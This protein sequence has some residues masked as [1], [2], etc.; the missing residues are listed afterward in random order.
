MVVVPLKALETRA[1]KTPFHFH[2]GNV[3]APN[4]RPGGSAFDDIVV[5]DDVVESIV[6]HEVPEVGHDNS[7][8]LACDIYLGGAIGHVRGTV[9][10]PGSI[11]TDDSTS[12][13]PD[14]ALSARCTML[15]LMLFGRF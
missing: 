2:A 9:G 5:R 14:K 8:F 10:K 4:A 15:D 13:E 12:M 6:W 11:P 3:A 7:D 1:E